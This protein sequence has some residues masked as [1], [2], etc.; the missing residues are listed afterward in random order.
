MKA[1]FIKSFNQEII[2]VK[3]QHLTMLDLLPY[4]ITWESE[5]RH[6][7]IENQKKLVALILKDK[8]HMVIIKSPYDK[9]ENDACIIDANSNIIWNLSVLLKQKTGVSNLLF[10][11]VYYIKDSFFLFIIM[12]NHDYRIEFNP[13]TGEFG[14]L[15][16]SR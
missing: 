4:A 15:I 5:D 14:E 3:N 10:S 1:K 16:E 9:I 2:K 11:D 8:Q 13:I 12:A 7:R 6:Y